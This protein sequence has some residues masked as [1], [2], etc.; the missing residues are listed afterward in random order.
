[1]KDLVTV[2]DG[3]VLH[4]HLNEALAP[5]DL[6]PGWM[7][8]WAGGSEGPAAPEALQSPPLDEV[9]AVVKAAAEASNAK[10]VRLS[11]G[12][13]LHYPGL[14]DL[15]DDLAALGK[16][17]TLVTPGHALADDQN[18]RPFA[19]YLVGFELCMPSADPEVSKLAFGV[20]IF[21]SL[22][23]GMRNLKAF[24]YRFS[25]TVPVYRDNVHT[26]AET[27]LHLGRAYTLR[28]VRVEV[29]NPPGGPTPWV[30]RY[31]AYSAV[32]EQLLAI[33]RDGFKPKPRVELAGVPAGQIP[34]EQFEQ[35]DVVVDPAPRPGGDI[36]SPPAAY[37]EQHG[38]PEVDASVLVRRRAIL[39]TPHDQRPSYR[40]DPRDRFADAVSVVLIR[41]GNPVFVAIE[42][43]VAGRPYLVGNESYGLCV[44]GRFGDAVLQSRFATLCKTVYAKE[45]KERLEIGRMRAVAHVLRRSLKPK[46]DHEPVELREESHSEE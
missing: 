30:H 18:V 40:G 17:M 41:P 43:K 33:E 5:G 10:M 31:P 44:Y 13:I 11:S 37:I 8:A 23:A 36:T 42:P 29:F 45:G 2:T 6:H 15:M 3:N 19:G 4:V 1:M 9:R 20:D 12:D 16:R 26:M 38:R 22:E 21:E 46:H 32:A 34:L 28:Q 7:R 39:A 14:F 27:V 24:A 25:V 35:L